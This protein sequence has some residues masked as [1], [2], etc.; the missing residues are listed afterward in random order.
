MGRAE[1]G[2]VDVGRMVRGSKWGEQVW[3]VD[4]GEV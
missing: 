3:E 4:G 2:M 1:M